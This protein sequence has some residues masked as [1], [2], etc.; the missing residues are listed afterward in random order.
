LIQTVSVTGKVTPIISADLSFEILG[1]IKDIPVKVGDKVKQGDK[2][3]ELNTPILETQ[4]SESRLE[5]NRQQEILNQTRRK[6]WKD[7]SPNEKASAKLIVEKTRMALKTSRQQLQKAILYAPFSGIISKK[8]FAKNEVVPL[9]S[10]VISIIDNQAG[11]EI[12]AQIPESDIAKISLGQIARASFDALPSNKTLSATVIK[13]EPSAT[14]IQDVVYYETTFSLP[15][16]K[17]SSLLS[18]L[19]SGMSVDLDITTQTKKN[20]LAVPSQAIKIDKQQKY[21]E[22]INKKN[23]Q[24]KKIIV[25]TGLQDDNGLMEITKGNLKIGDR[26]V[27]FI[28]K[29]KK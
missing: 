27:T 22:T 14:V 16:D 10:P 3:A 21:V 6:N 7:L 23:N 15:N 20:I 24:I 13:I 8:Y 18:S 29:K 17:S 5:L 2:V 19:R 12:K 28:N 4:L 26:V 9:G 11:L 1:T 25:Q